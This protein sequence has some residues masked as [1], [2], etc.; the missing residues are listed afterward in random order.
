MS[1]V[2]KL[3]DAR[4]DIKPR[5]PFLMVLADRDPCRESTPS[6]ETAIVRSSG[7][8]RPIRSATPST[9]ITSTDNVCSCCISCY[10]ISDFAALVDCFFVFPLNDAMSGPHMSFAILKSVVVTLKLIPLVAISIA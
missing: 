10:P 1:L 2:T 9:Y 5:M 8:A 3:R 7:D 4:V 6:R